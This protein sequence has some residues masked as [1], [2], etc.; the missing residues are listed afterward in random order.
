LK[1]TYY[2]QTKIGKIEISEDGAGITN[3]DIADEH[4]LETTEIKETPLLKKAATQLEEYLSGN[5]KI[6]DL[7]LNPQG[8]EFQKKV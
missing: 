6:F 2:Y 8:T 3:L 4:T 7:P 1:N 5:R